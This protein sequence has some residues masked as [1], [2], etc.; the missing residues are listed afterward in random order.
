MEV[1]AMKVALIKFLFW[2]WFG[3]LHLNFGMGS[4]TNTQSLA[5]VFLLCALLVFVRLGVVKKR[6]SGADWPKFLRIGAEI[7]LLMVILGLVGNLVLLA[8]MLGNGSKMPVAPQ[9]YAEFRDYSRPD[10][11]DDGHVLATTSTRFFP[12]V[13]YIRAYP[14]SDVSGFLFPE[15]SYVS[16]GDLL[17]AASVVVTWWVWILVTAWSLCYAMHRMFCFHKK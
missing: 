9:T 14:S 2:P 6:A 3:R 8:A 10:G 13:D 1:I 17:V 11:L 16:P 12:L 5:I 7:V 15:N 4:L